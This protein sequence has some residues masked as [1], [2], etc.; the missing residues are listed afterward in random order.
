MEQ[1]FLLDVHRRC[2]LLSLDKQQFA[3]NVE[4]CSLNIA[5]HVSAFGKH[6][7]LV[8]ALPLENSTAL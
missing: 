7:Q 8:I 1:M 5:N 3:L 2:W 6:Q 4:H